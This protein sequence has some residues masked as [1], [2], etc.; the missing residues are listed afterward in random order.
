VFS[1][2]SHEYTRALL[3]AA[4]ELNDLST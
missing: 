1:N 4:L 2:P 3:D